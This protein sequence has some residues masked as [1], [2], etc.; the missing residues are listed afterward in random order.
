MHKTRILSIIL[1]ISGSSIQHAKNTPPD[2]HSGNIW[3]QAAKMVK[4]NIRAGKAVRLHTFETPSLGFEEK[5]RSPTPKSPGG[6]QSKEESRLGFTL[7][8]LTLM[9]FMNKHER[10]LQNHEAHPQMLNDF[11]K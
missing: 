5:P 1:A 10:E 3:A 9:D 8:K 11:N 2:T 7:L 6:S 4:M